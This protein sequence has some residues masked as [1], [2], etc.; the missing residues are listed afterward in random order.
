[1][2]PEWATSRRRR[3]LGTDRTGLGAMVDVDKSKPPGVECRGRG[4]YLL[5][6][7]SGPAALVFPSAWRK[8]STK[9][10]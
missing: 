7:E 4:V 8:A 10:V 3:A 5:H 9:D 1:M 6:T 2:P